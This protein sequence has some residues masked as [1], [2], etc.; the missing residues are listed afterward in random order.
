MSNQKKAVKPKIFR[1]SI[2][3]RLIVHFGLMLF[4]FGVVIA[5]ALQFFQ[6]VLSQNRIMGE[7][8][9]A[10]NSIVHNFY[11]EWTIR[12]EFEEAKNLNDVALNRNMQIWVKLL[13]PGEGETREIIM[14][15][16][17]YYSYELKE[18]KVIEEKE[19]G[20]FAEMSHTIGEDERVVYMV[21]T[22]VYTDYY[23]KDKDDNYDQY[24]IEI[25]S[26]LASFKNTSFIDNNYNRVIIGVA[27]AVALVWTWMY[28]R[29]FARPVIEMCD[30]TKNLASLNFDKRCEVDSD[31]EISDLAESI[32]EMSD[33]LKDALGE[34]KDKNQ[35]LV[36]ELEK[37]K[38]QELYRKKLLSDVSHEL[39][40]PLAIIS[41]YA[42]A[43]QLAA[44]KTAEKRNYYSNVII[45]EA[46]KM[47]KLVHD[48][49]YLSQVE[50]RHYQMLP[51][52]ISADQFLSEIIK[53]HSQLIA[54]RNVEIVFE[55]AACDILA[56]PLRLEQII[57]NILSNA[58]SQVQG[59][60]I[61]KLS[62]EVTEDGMY[63]ISVYN[64]GAHIADEDFDKLWLPFFKADKSRNRKEGRYGI[65]LSIVKELTEQQGGRYGVRNVTGTEDG[66]VFNIDMPIY[67]DDPQ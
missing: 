57:N 55:A 60:R 16:S 38:G 45:E 9:G 4:I 12:Q 54:D 64:S 35:L 33:K 25:R 22:R 52:R 66:V 21:Y 44:N 63:S 40:T 48:I 1:K 20:K 36:V 15:R 34:L 10:Y 47:S 49:L 50:G 32:N 30:I 43:L 29:R 27:F 58:L 41:G 62:G 7:M 18:D 8:R 28:S 61:I 14:Y 53:R 3:L 42:E 46:N 24:L 5:I 2:A 65:G 67:N 23:N 56:D 39:K 31:D 6:D 13:V 59:S 17:S 37:E 51:E 19:T 11:S 26:H